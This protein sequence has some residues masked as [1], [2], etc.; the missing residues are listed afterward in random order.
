MLPL[1]SPTSKTKGLPPVGESNSKTLGLS[2][3]SP[4]ALESR[5]RTALG[6][7]SG[8]KSTIGSPAG[9]MVSSVA[10][11]DWAAIAAG[12]A[13]RSLR[14]IGGRERA[15][16]IIFRRATSR[17]S[18]RAAPTIVFQ[19]SQSPASEPGESWR[20][21]LSAEDDD[22][23]PPQRHL[24]RIEVGAAPEIIANPSPP[25]SPVRFAPELHACAQNEEAE[26]ENLDLR[27]ML[28]RTSD[29]VAV[30]Q[31]RVATCRADGGTK[32][33]KKK[34]KAKSPGK[35]RSMSPRKSAASPCLGPMNS[36]AETG[37][38]DRAQHVGV[39]FAMAEEE[40]R[41]FVTNAE[42]SKWKLLLDKNRMVGSGQVK[43]A[44]NTCEQ[45]DF[46]SVVEVEAAQ[47]RTIPG[48]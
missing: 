48:R 20:Q 24:S 35:A 6:P 28:E 17:G 5:V 39:A 41:F 38:R 7:E 9:R 33:G 29:L 47:A 1:L 40:D 18:E 31:R 13:G 46:M 27:Q 42:Q 22:S 3:P 14:A 21:T 36:P 2:A 25:Q 30:A 16:P 4:K 19:C 15:P 43:C 32:H 11:K 44:K 23:L 12:G 37:S 34:K 8:G 26:G 45:L 10:V